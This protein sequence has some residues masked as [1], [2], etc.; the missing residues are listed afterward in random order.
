M[1]RIRQYHDSTRRRIGET[2]TDPH[3]EPRGQQD[4]D[5]AAVG[6]AQQTCDIECEPEEDHLPGVSAIRKRSDGHLGEE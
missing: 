5:A 2:D 4:D 1:F 6:H 3:H